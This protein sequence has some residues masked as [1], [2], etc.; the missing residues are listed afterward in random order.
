RRVVGGGIRGARARRRG[1]GDR[2]GPDLGDARDPRG[3]RYRVRAHERH[4]A[5]LALEAREGIP[6][7]TGRYLLTRAS[8]ETPRRMLPR[9]TAAT[10]RGTVAPSAPWVPWLPGGRA[11]PSRDRSC[12]ALR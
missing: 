5:P 1:A 12:S 8:Q 2:A 6:C 4:D 11:E 10:S 3:A 7:V 9:P